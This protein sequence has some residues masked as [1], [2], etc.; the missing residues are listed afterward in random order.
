MKKIKIFKPVESM[1]PKYLGTLEEELYKEIMDRHNGR[2][3]AEVKEDGYRMQV[4]KKGNKIKAYT[5]SMNGIILELFPEL[6][7]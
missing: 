7:N 3:M 4:H 5:R 2:T 1:N 6:N